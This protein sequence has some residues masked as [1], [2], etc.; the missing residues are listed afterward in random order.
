[1]VLEIVTAATNLDDLERILRLADE[2]VRHKII[3]LPDREAAR[4]GLLGRRGRG[5]PDPP[6]TEE[7]LPWQ[8]TTTSPSSATSPATPNCASPRAGR[9]SPPSGWPS[10]AVG[11]TVRPR[12]GRSGLL[13]RRHLLGPARPRTSA[14]R[15]PRAPASSSPAASTSA[16]G[17]PRTATSA[18][19]SRSSP[20]RS[21]PACAGRPPRSP[22]T[23]ARRRRR[24]RRRRQRRWRRRRQPP[25]ANE[26]PG[27]DPDEEPF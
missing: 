8:T 9:P 25:V 17:R 4:R 10:T 18:R 21:R 20:T 24:R 19:R 23:S 7:S 13:L 6:T 2:V 27:Y 15:S 26:P 14:S 3:R 5:R 12:S 11:R 1:M 16:P 22:R